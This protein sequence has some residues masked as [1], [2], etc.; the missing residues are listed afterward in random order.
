MKEH[1]LYGKREYNIDVSRETD[2]A[3]CIHTEV[4][5]HDVEKRCA[6][7]SWGNSGRHLYGC[8]TCVHQYTRFDKDNIPC[9]RCTSFKGKL[10][11]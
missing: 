8:E 1:W 5:D 2:C 4:C 7:Y 6:N 3:R 9:F 10:K 11:K